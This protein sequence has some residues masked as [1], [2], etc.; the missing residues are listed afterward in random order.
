[1]SSP[2]GNYGYSDVIVDN[3]NII[4]SSGKQL[5]EISK[6][7]WN[8]ITYN[9]G[10]GL[11]EG[12]TQFISGEIKINDGINISNEMSL[13]GDEI[14]ELKFRTPQKQEID[15]VGRVYNVSF[16]KPDKNTKIVTLKFC[17]AEKVVADQLKINRAYRQVLYSEIAKDIFVP[18]N[19][20]G[21]KK[22]YAEPT[23]NM[24]NFIIN[25]KSPIDAMNQ[26][27]RV[28]RSEKYQGAN[29]VFFER[30]DN[31][32]QFASIESLV[33]P[34]K[35]KPVIGYTVSVPTGKKNDLK[36]LVTLQSYQVLSF[37]NIITNIQSGVYASTLVS[38]DLMK[39]K[40]SYNTFNYD[41]TYG[42]YSSVN[43]NEISG[44]GQGKTSITNNVKYSQRPSSKMVFVPNHYNSFDVDGN[45][46]DEL[47]DTV[48][49]R[50]SQLRQIN[51][52]RLRIAVSG[53][54]QR[55][56]G[57]L[58]ELKIPTMEQQGGNFDDMLSGRYLISKVK[59]IISSAAPH[60]YTTVMDI[61]KDSFETPLPQKA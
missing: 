57:E 29:Y 36:N 37:P 48:L 53:D 45:Y 34:K 41:E 40:V 50:N 2:E 4:S 14:V 44:Y 20:I 60:G 8:A 35:N 3:C 15:F 24:G 61:V 54:S 56:A 46:N 28:S 18:F 1:M 43:Y 7:S 49:V 25:N 33:D 30:S 51:A 17:S 31:I 55:R 22:I 42:D 5:N 59:H 39:R 9:E 32:F 10:M 58:I 11:L 52:I 13:S 6:K 47:K 21:N 19:K 26:I 12:D 27:A 38:N 23:K 16:A